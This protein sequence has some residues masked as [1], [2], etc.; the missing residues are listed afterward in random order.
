MSSAELDRRNAQARAPQRD[1]TWERKPEADRLSPSQG[2]GCQANFRQA[3]E[4]TQPLQKPVGDCPQPELPRNM[5][6]ETRRN[7]DA[8]AE[9]DRNGAPPPA[10]PAGP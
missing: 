2:G 9:I 10:P 6:M 4:A 8:M 1:G 3:G 5:R 7:A